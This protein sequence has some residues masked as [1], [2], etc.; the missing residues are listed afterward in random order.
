MCRR[1]ENIYK[2]KDGRWEGRYATGRKSN[3]K[4]QF[5]SVY[6]STYAQVRECLL[7]LKCKQQEAFRA[8]A[9]PEQSFEDWTRYW[10]EEVVRTRIKPSTYQNYSRIITKH[11]LP[12][13][14][15]VSL[16]TLQEDRL[17]QA[18]GE[19]QTNLAPGTVQ[20]IFRVLKSI[21]KCAHERKLC[22]EPWLG[23]RVSGKSKRPRVLSRLE[24]KELETAAL[25]SH[26]PEVIVSLYTGLRVGELCGLQWEDIDWRESCIRVKRSVQRLN[27]GGGATRLVVSTPKSEASQRDIPLH[28]FLLGKLTEWKEKRTTGYILSRKAAAAADPRTVQARFAKLVQAVGITGA[29]MHTLRHTFATRCLEQNV[30]FEVLSELLGHSSPQVTMN[31]YAH[32]TDEQKRLSIEKLV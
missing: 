22:G 5:R 4:L 26:T 6:A 17:Q 16:G 31:F 15:P 20:G 12:A 30:G 24:Q 10:L 25:E 2:R 1:G 9:Y 3:G 8:F 21:L 32:C 27:C 29:H 28:P 14:G 19:W 13:L 18:L 11:L 23:L 7:R